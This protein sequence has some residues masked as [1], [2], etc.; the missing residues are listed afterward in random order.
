MDQRLDDSKY[1]IIAVDDGSTDDSYKVLANFG[2]R[3]ETLRLDDNVGL[4]SAINHGLQIAKGRHIV[5]VDAD[6]YVHPEFLNSLQLFMDLKAD[7]FDA[8]ATDYMKVDE[9]GKKLSMHDAVAEPIACG[10]LFKFEALVKVGF[11]KEGLRFGEDQELREKFLGAGMRIG[12]LPMPLYRY[13]QHGN[14]LS[15]KSLLT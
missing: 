4:A 6:D 1:E 11:Y 2:N 10:I 13:T 15:D 8:V 3:I 14:S 12:H 7:S 9:I 5:R